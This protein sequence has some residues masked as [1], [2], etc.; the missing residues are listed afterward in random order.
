MTSHRS[1]PNLRHAWLTILALVALPLVWHLT[2]LRQWVDFPTLASWQ[3]AIRASPSAPLIVVAAYLAAAVTFFP[4]TVL[5]M[6][7]VFSFGPVAGG[8]YSMIGWLLSAML[9]YFFGRALGQD[10][11]WEIAGP[12]LK[13][14]EAEA[15]RHG[16]AAVLIMRLLPLAPFTLV[17]LFIGA[18]RICFRHFFLGSIVGR[19]PG[20]ILAALVALQLELALRVPEALRWAGLAG[21][22]L[23][24]AGLA[25]AARRFRKK[26]ARWTAWRKGA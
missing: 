13:R 3:G 11:L 4:I 6:V 8:A 20:L 19:T 14:L 17:N 25:V 24:A 21:A 9:G 10:L 5:T 26:P 16:F 18:S 23:I 12:R 7:T 22:V 2:P 1:S 15:R